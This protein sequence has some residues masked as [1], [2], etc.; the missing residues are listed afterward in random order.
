MAVGD[1]VVVEAAQRCDEM[2]GRAAA[3]S[4]VAAC[5]DVRLDVL[6]QSLD[7]GRVG[8]VQPSVT[9]LIKHAVPV[10]AIHPAGT[11]AHRGRYYRNVLG[12]RRRWWS[13][14]YG[15]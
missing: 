9:P 12:E 11:G 1:G 5:H 6:G 15:V 4:G 13:S 10:G 2:F 14:G 7:V 8:F 3:A